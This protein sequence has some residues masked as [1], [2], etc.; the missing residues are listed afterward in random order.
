MIQTNLPWPLVALFI[1]CL[2]DS[3]IAV[4]QPDSDQT[5]SCG[6]IRFS[7]PRDLTIEKVADEPLIKWPIVADWDHHGRLVVAESGGVGW[8]IQEHNKQRLHKIVRLIDTDGDGHFDQRL[9]AAEDLAFPE[10]VLCLGNDLLV[11]APPVIWRLSDDDDDGICE[12]REVWFDGTTVTN[13][14][15]DLHGPYLGRDGW[16]YWC[17][18][19]FGKQTHDLIDGTNRT[20]S[21]AHIYRRRASGGPIESLI[22]GGMD[23]PV[24]VAITP[25]GD[26]FFTS[27]FLVH[28]GNGQR[29]GIAHAVYGGVFGKDHHVVDDQVRTGPLMEPMTHLGPAAPS[30]LIYAESNALKQLFGFQRNARPLVAA[31]FNLHKV[32]TH[33]LL[34]SGATYRTN[35]RDVLSTDQVDFHPT[36]VIEDADGSLLILDTGGWYDLCCPTSRVDQKTASGGVYRLSAAKGRVALSSRA[37]AIDWDSAT[38]DSVVK[39]LFDDRSWVRRSAETRLNSFG[40]SAI[41]ELIQILWD[42][43]RPL[44]HRQQ[45]LWALCRLESDQADQAVAESIHGTA[46]PLALTALSV[47][48]MHRCAAARGDVET[49][50]HHDSLLVRRKAAETLGRIGDTR[51]LNPLLEAYA[52]AGADRH[53]K[54]ASVFALI[55]ITRKHRTLDLISLADTD[56]KRNAVFISLRETDRDG[57]IGS[58]ASFEALKSENEDL[59]H[60]ATQILAKHSQWASESVDEL[61]KLW[62]QA[63][64]T[65]SDLSSVLVDVLASWK[66]DSQVSEFL[67]QRIAAAAQLPGSQQ[68]FLANHLSALCSRPMDKTTAERITDWIKAAPP[69]TRQRIVSE[70]AKM[71]DYSSESTSLTDMIQQQAATS[72]AIEDRLRWLTALPEGFRIESAALQNDVVEAF[73]SD[74]DARSSAAANILATTKLDAVNAKRIADSIADVTARNLI[75]AIKTVQRSADDATSR[76]MLI[77]LAELPTARTLRENFLDDLFRKASPQLREQAA[78]TSRALI[79]PPA[80]IQVIVTKTLATI[81]TGDPV[82]G[83]QVFRSSKAACSACHRM[84]Y[85]GKDIGPEL[86]RIGRSRTREA[87]LEAILFPNSRQEQSYQSSQILTVD[88]DVFNGIVKDRSNGIV[89]LQV[90]ADRVVEIEIDQIEIDKPS[91]VSLMPSGIRELLSDA[92][93]ADVLA[94][95]G[96]AK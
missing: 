57:E 71:G 42:A 38:L 24:E 80:D 56:A 47:L 76:E 48:S 30:G 79:R 27:T 69:Q 6:G 65:P 62:E 91:D 9:V 4:A 43:S 40:N 94:L 10:G 29:D 44:D 12:R 46:T 34:P 51:S 90:A 7:L 63:A 81:G 55:E 45:A 35:D 25:E 83:L 13:C 73:L 11:S 84:G 68:Q 3:G 61:A 28:P 89:K 32:T 92:E 52:S 1:S 78:A 8:P 49:L 5:V 60:T 19:A 88:G 77:G 58:A 23:N 16:I 14:A 2:L 15:N 36:D 85:I 53:L 64:A 18:G 66:G 33:E 21:A 17:K 86:T 82:A 37:A 95:L 41:P 93:L 20:S 22:S 31:L 87:L 72:D 70:L 74:D 96:S 54:H 59:R 39:L 67:G 75:T 26:T 50:L